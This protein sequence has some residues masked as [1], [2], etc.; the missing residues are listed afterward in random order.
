MLQ[1]GKSVVHLVSKGAHG[2]IGF[3]R[4]FGTEPMFFDL[5]CVKAC[6][7]FRAG[8]AEIA[9][10]ICNTNTR[11]AAGGM[12][13]ELPYENLPRPIF[14]FEEISEKDITQAKRYR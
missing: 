6:T 10:E 1:I 13:T 4:S 14:P 7:S 8:Y 3:Y 12:L 11:G 5:I 2:D 9:G